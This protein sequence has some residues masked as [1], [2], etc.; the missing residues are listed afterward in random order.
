MRIDPLVAGKLSGIIVTFEQPGD[1][2][3][4][5]KHGPEDCHITIVAIGPVRIYG[6][7]IGDATYNS[8]AVIDFP[9]GK[10]HDIEGREAGTRVVNITKGA[11]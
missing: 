10:E 2:L 8:G 9:P 4:M 3:G 7:E 1:H 6:P 11:A 5:H